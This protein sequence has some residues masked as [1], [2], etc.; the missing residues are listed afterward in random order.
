MELVVGNLVARFTAET[1]EFQRAM[2]DMGRV[3][4]DTQ[5]SM[6]DSA[7]AVTALENRLD[8][9]RN[10]WRL[11]VIGEQ[12][13]ATAIKQV[14][15]DVAE[16]ASSSTLSAAGI[17][18]LAK[19]GQ[20]ATRELRSVTAVAKRTADGFEAMGVAALAASQVAV[21]GITGIGR[22]ASSLGVFALGSP[23]MIGIL[24]GVSALAAAWDLVSKN[25]KDAEAA[26]EGFVHRHR[27]AAAGR[28]SVVQEAIRNAP[29]QVPT[30]VF[31]R[32]GMR[33]TEMIDNP[34]IP[35]L[36][37]EEQRLLIEVNTLLPTRVTHER[38]ISDE[39][40]QHVQLIRELKDGLRDTKAAVTGIGDAWKNMKED[41]GKV[42]TLG[43]DFFKSGKGDLGK[44]SG[45]F[46]LK[47]GLDPVLNKAREYGGAFIDVGKLIGESLIVMAESIGHG[48]K[49]MGKIMLGLLGNIMVEVGKSMIMFGAAMKALKIA[50][51][52]PVVAIAA[53]I[54]L[55]ALGS[56]LGASAQ[57]AVNSGGEGGG[58][59]GGSFASAPATGGTGSSD[60]GS[61][62]FILRIPRGGF[63]MDPNNPDDMDR[64]MAML[65][66]ARRSR[67]TEIEVYDA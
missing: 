20:T 21:G 10:Q 27:E 33:S 23:A 39:M 3:N 11:N 30:T 53:G 38:H 4:S 54:G 62:T 26:A 40:R 63:G 12:E 43:A 65:R 35:A 1:A 19:V 7:S 28:L 44:H 22:A 56:A 8:T 31:G 46:G 52:N 16:M 51:K 45:V 55:V 2:R 60:E 47:E 49:G 24:A 14:R 48:F 57:H 66:E 29:A 64:L 18:R 34:A 41:L 6:Q 25:T 15:A 59:A 37:A 13:F 42:M 17:D 67:R 50:I 61:G 32:S 9:L 36:R 5:R 58:S